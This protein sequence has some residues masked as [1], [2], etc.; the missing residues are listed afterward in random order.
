MQAKHETPG[1]HENGY[2]S[3]AALTSK[4]DASEFTPFAEGID[5]LM[6]VEINGRG[7]AAGL[8]EAARAKAATPSRDGRGAPPARSPGGEWRGCLHR[9]RLPDLPVLHA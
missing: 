8:F 1:G 6:S 7:V 2:G 9:D 3:G 5:R 4:D